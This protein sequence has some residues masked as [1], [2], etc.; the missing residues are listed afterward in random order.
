MAKLPFLTQWGEIP[1]HEATP[2]GDIYENKYAEELE[3][4]SDREK[5][6]R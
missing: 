6:R 5:Q 3:R 1:E 2:A 4:N